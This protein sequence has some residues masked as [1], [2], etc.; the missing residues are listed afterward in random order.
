MPSSPIRVR[1]EIASDMAQDITE[2]RQ[3]KQLQS[4]IFSQLRSEEQQREAEAQQQDCESLA[5]LSRLLLELVQKLREER[6]ALA[7]Q[8]NDQNRI[9][10]L[11]RMADEI[12][13]FAAGRRDEAPPEF[14]QPQATAPL[15]SFG[16]PPRRALGASGRPAQSTGG[17]SYSARNDRAA[18]AL[19]S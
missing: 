13:A 3:L 19:R 5:R 2:L 18:W 9:V 10:N 4:H 12:M 8:L 16:Q 11:R 17:Y 1:S 7:A 6:D 15:P 14:V